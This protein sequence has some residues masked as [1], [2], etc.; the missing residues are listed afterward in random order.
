[1]SLEEISNIIK[2]K[3]IEFKKNK[4][5]EFIYN[6]IKE[7]PNIEVIS[8]IYKSDKLKIHG[9]ISKKKNLKKKVPVV[10]YCRG[11]NNI[12]IN[13]RNGRKFGELVEGRFYSLELTNLVNE[14]KIIL[15]A[16]NYRGS[17]LSEG[18]DE[19]GG[20]DINDIINLYPIIKKYKYSDEKNICLYGWSRGCTMVMN[21]HKKV[22]WIKCIILGAGNYNNSLDKKFRP[23]MYKILKTLFSL[24]EENKKKR[25]A[26]YWIDKL[27]KN[28]PILILHGSADWRVSVDNAYLLGQAL[29][30][31]KIPYKLVIYPGGDHGLLEYK[32]EV[33]L[34]RNNFLESYLLDNKQKYINLD[35]HGN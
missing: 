2:F 8:M 20:R 18:K 13:K 5:P 25:S 17:T 4:Y 32:K 27:K 29:Q 12:S 22:K 11:G 16:S 34:E 6:K 28:V 35:N 23:D 10:I 9:Y 33:A 1:M 19:F 31:N 15:F 26:I 3:K 21:V 14:G 30:K 7:Y 24:S